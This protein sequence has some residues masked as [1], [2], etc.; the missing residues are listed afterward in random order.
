M[1][2][3]LLQSNIYDCFGIPNTLSTN[4]SI[5]VFIL[6]RGMYGMLFFLF[7]AVLEEKRGQ[8]AMLNHFFSYEEFIFL[9]YKD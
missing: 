7:T 4:I 5:T 6:N 9:F 1:R 8:K 2:V 3:I